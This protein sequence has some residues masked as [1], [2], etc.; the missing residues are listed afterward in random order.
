MAGGSIQLVEA[1]LRGAGGLNLS[2]LPWGSS[3]VDTNALHPIIDQRDDNICQIYRIVVVVFGR[4]GPA[5]LPT[6]PHF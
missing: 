2:I 1:D 6:S 3:R 5:R 4:R